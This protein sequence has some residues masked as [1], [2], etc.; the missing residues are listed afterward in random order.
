LKTLILS[1][2]I[3]NIPVATG[4]LSWVQNENIP[5]DALALVGGLETVD[6][7]PTVGGQAVRAVLPLTAL[8]PRA[9]APGLLAL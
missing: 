3:K 1:S 4:T 8:A 5:L 9:P 7:L 6:T 2:M